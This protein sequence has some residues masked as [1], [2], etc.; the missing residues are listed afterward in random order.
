[1][2]DI[3]SDGQYRIA[4][5]ASC[6]R[7]DDSRQQSNDDERVCDSGHSHSSPG[8]LPTMISVDLM[9]AVTW[10]P[11]LRPRAS[12]DPRVIAA[13]SDFPP[14]M[15]MLTSAIT[16]PIRMA[17]TRP[18]SWFRA[19]ICMVLSPGKLQP[20]TSPSCSPQNVVRRLVPS[21]RRG[22]CVESLPR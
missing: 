19:L 1:M 2:L 16:L 10:S 13:V 8:Y 12:A 9:I 4:L 18:G 6:C 15:S 22:A 17:V 11:S 7:E 5:S 14:P 20:R 21:E 3:P